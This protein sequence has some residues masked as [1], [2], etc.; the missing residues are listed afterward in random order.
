AGLEGY[1]FDLPIVRR[2]GIDI[3]FETSVTII[4]GENGTGKCT[5]LEAIAEAAGFGSAGGS[6]N[7]TRADEAT[8]KYRDRELDD[9]DEAARPSKIRALADARRDLRLTDVLR[10]SWLPK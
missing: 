5:I 9:F 7:H 4:A 10:C 6:R 1:P 2:G 8:E 3:S